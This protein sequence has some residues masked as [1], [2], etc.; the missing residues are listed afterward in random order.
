MLLRLLQL[1]K[2]ASPIVVTELGISNWSKFLHAKKLLSPIVFI[3]LGIITS[4][5]HWHPLNILLFIELIDCDKVTD[6]SFSQC[7]NNHS[8]IDTTEL[9]NT[10][11]EIISQFIKAALSILAT[12]G[13]I[14]TE[15]K[16][17]QL[18]NEY[19]PMWVT[20]WAIFMLDKLLWKKAKSPIDVIPSSIITLLYCSFDHGA[21]FLLV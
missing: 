18:A 21:F 19:L 11:L 13:G 10:I 17:L 3:L 15:V 2:A 1:K 4:F 20:E 5:K 14:S 12:E 8:P 6:C 9:G 7:A 16:Y